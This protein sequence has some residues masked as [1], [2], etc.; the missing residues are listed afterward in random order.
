MQPDL[1]GAGSGQTG[2]AGVYKGQADR[3]AVKRGSQSG[4]GDSSARLQWKQSTG[5]VVRWIL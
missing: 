5:R 2:S 1:A 3:Q 4:Q